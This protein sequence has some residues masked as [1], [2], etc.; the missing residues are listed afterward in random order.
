MFSPSKISYPTQQEIRDQQN[1]QLTDQIFTDQ[2]F[3]STP[4]LP[5]GLPFPRATGDKIVLSE[6]LNHHLPNA[7]QT[8][9]HGPARFDV[10]AC[11]QLQFGENTRVPRIFRAPP[12]SI[13]IVDRL[14]VGGGELADTRFDAV[15]SRLN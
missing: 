4:I 2:L 3:Q 9:D 1:Q 8:T 12:Q 11:N 5:Q 7:N 15:N 14:D 10:D 6:V 13:T